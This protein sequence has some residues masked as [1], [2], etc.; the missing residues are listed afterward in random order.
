VG[1]SRS[2]EGMHCGMAIGSSWHSFLLE[3]PPCPAHRLLKTA[4]SARCFQTQSS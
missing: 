3:I 4:G 2:L 1:V